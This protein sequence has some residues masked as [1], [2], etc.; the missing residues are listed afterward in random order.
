[1][2][3]ERDCRRR[4]VEPL[5]HPPSQTIEGTDDTAR[6]AL[7]YVR[8]DLRRGHIGVTE[9]VLHGADVSARFQ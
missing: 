9:Q 6:T 8:V 1:L 7:E 4:Q 2:R 5:P 3:A